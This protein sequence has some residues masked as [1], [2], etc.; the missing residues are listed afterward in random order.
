MLENFS[1]GMFVVLGWV[2]VNKQYLAL[3]RGKLVNMH[4]RC[5]LCELR[6]EGKRSMKSLLDQTFGVIFFYSRA[7]LGRKVRT[8]M[9][10]NSNAP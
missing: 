1:A 5:H 6:A 3:P 2:C 4:E 8:C 7:A 10:A 9:F